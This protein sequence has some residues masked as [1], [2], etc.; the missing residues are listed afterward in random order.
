MLPLLS[1]SHLAILQIG[2]VETCISDGNLKDALRLV[3]AWDLASR[4]PSLEGEYE[5]RTMDKLLSKSL[6]NAAA[7]YAIGK[8]KFQ[9]WAFS[10]LRF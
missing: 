10:V 1:N 5:Q 8:P 9:V 7:G 3:K 4:Y 6:W 2:L